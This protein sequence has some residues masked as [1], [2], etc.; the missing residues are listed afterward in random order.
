MK[1]TILLILGLC[2]FVCSCNSLPRYGPGS[3]GDRGHPPV[4]L[5]SYAA[6][7]IQP[8]WTWRVYLHARDEDADMKSIALVLYQTGIGYHATEI[9]WIKSEHTEEFAGYIYLNTPV[10]HNLLPD[11][12]SLLILVRDEQG[13]KSEPIEF[14]LRFGFVLPQDILEQWR[15]ANE[16][17]PLMI[18]I[19]GSATGPRGVSVQ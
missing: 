17:G 11:R 2:F 15:L 16:L 19:R 18:H 5:D 13:N 12:C 10:D 14:P 7:I 8:G 4:V 6:K 3:E 9:K 1:K